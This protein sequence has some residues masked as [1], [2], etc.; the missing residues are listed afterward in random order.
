MEIDMKRQKTNDNPK[1]KR[2]VIR[3]EKKSSSLSLRRLLDMLRD[4]KG[5][6]KHKKFKERLKKIKPKKDEFIPDKN[7]VVIPDSKNRS[8]DMY[9]NKKIISD[10]TAQGV[11]ALYT[12][13][14]TGH[15]LVVKIPNKGSEADIINEKKIYRYLTKKYQNTICEKIIPKHYEFNGDFDGNKIYVALEYIS[16][17]SL[18][19]KLRKSYQGLSKEDKENLIEKVQNS[20]RC[21][22]ETGVV[23]GDLHASNIMVHGKNNDIKIFDFGASMIHK[24]IKNTNYMH[25]W[26]INKHANMYKKY[27]STSQSVSP[28]NPNIVWFGHRYPFYAETHRKAIDKLLLN[29]RKYSRIPAR[30]RDDL[31]RIGKFLQIH[32]YD[33]KTRKELEF[34]IN[35][36]DSS[37][38][39]KRVSKYFH[40]RQKDYRHRT[41][42]LKMIINL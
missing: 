39:K 27:F 26:F 1:K 2:K 18:I 19:N 30:S 35:K 24:P 22:W 4:K 34:A 5:K 15:K 37:F 9:G 6:D 42:L 11:V 13:K 36:L 41:D 7:I 28:G 17:D 3:K 33:K 38:I 32:G 10:D 25:N 20:I 14:K 8:Q 16:G 12:H 29:T 23:H 31:N 40:G 21:L